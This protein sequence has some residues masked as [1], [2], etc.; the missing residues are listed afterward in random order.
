MLLHF[1]YFIN[2]QN[3][4]IIYKL[5]LLDSYYFLCWAYKNHKEEIG[6][7]E[8]MPANSRT[9]PKIQVSAGEPARTKIKKD[10]NKKYADLPPT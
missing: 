8:K 4:L 10:N 2:I 7:E 1:I 6:E 9:K 3:I 5:M